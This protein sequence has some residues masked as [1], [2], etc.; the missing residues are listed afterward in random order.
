LGREEEAGAD[1]DKA[2]ELGFDPKATPEDAG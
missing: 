2:K 1:R